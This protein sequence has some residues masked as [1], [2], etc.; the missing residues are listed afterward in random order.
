MLPKKP[1]PP[2]CDLPR[3]QH[4]QQQQQPDMIIAANRFLGKGKNAK[5]WW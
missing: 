4:H 1:Q 5:K 2:R 3:W